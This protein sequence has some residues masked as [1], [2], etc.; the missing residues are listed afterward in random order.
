MEANRLMLELKVTNFPGWGGGASKA[1]VKKFQV[2]PI[3]QDL[4]TSLGFLKN[5]QRTP[6]VLFIWKL[7]PGLI[8]PP[9]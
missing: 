9:W 2:M 4:G 3:K 7:L 5:M 8:L 6:P 1:W